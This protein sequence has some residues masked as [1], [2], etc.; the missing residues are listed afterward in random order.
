[1][2]GGNHFVVGV[3][4]FKKATPVHLD[5]YTLADA[6]RAKA[7]Q[8]VGGETPMHICTPHPAERGTMVDV[9]SGNHFPLNGGGWTEEAWNAFLQR[10]WP[11]A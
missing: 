8:G 2:A 3:Y 5:G 1:M 10:T 9:E 6:K 7:W 11:E 4:G